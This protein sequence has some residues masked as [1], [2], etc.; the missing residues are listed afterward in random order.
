MSD[1]VIYTGTVVHKR[2]RPKTHALSYRVFSMLF[3]LDRLDEL[4]ARCRL[5]SVN[6]GNVFSFFESDHG[7]GAPAGLNRHIRSLMSAGGIDLSPDGRL[8]AL[9]YP[10]MFGYVFNPLTVYY[11]LDGRGCMEGIVYEVNNTWGER[12]CYVAPVARGETGVQAQQAQKRMHVSPF[13]SPQGS[14]GFRVTDPGDQLTVGVHLCDADGALLKT[15]FTG[16]AQPLTDRVL[17][18]LLWRYPLMT[19]KVIAGI[20]WEALRLWIKGV[21]VTHG[22]STPGYRVSHIA[23]ANGKVTDVA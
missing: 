16:K 5:F 4:D 11:A 17:A 3:D 6:R 23:A 21:P 12:H 13:A 20:H 15:H 10:R 1:A 18:S 19:W 7:Q 9:C 2:L 14:Y 22:A 8:L